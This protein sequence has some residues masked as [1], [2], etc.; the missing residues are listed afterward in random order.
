[1]PKFSGRVYFSYGQKLVFKLT[2]GG[3]V[4]PVSLGTFPYVVATQARVLKPDF[5]ARSSTVVAPY[6]DPAA[7]VATASAPP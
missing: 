6:A 5:A 3:L 2:T 4:Q 7:L 1:M